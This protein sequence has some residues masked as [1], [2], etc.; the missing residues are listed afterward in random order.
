MFPGYIEG[1]IGL[2]WVNRSAFNPLN[3]NPTKWLNTLKQFVS[4]SL[5]IVSMLVTIIWGVGTQRVKNVVS[6]PTSF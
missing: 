4:N 6:W 2:K 5:Q 1:I 3:A